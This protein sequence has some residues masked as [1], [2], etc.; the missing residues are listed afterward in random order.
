[1]N[2]HKIIT[3]AGF[4]LGSNF[5]FIGCTLIDRTT[6]AKHDTLHALWKNNTKA[7]LSGSQQKRITAHSRGNQFCRILDGA[8]R[9]IIK[10]IDWQLSY[11]TLERAEKAGLIISKKWI[12]AGKPNL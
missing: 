6:L 8:S 5:S 2:N 10:E 3:R 4:T 12:D 1:M 9:A 11:D 7:T